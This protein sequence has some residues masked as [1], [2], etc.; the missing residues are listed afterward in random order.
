MTLLAALAISSAQIEPAAASMSAVQ[1]FKD[2]CSQGSLK[3]S[4]SQGRVLQD[5]ERRPDLVSVIG[6]YR[7]TS[8]PTVIKFNYPRSTYLIFAE[9][10]DAQ[11]RGIDRV[12]VLWSRAITKRD[13]MQALMETAPGIAP[14]QTWIPDM[15]LPEWTIDVPQLG[16]RTRMKI[17]RD[18]SIFLEVANYRARAR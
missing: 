7:T 12:C 17:Q 4:P 2:G 13:A 11:P 18:E 14:K 6:R 9:Y 10:R 16:Y 8:K 5:G 15:H 1:A 3:L